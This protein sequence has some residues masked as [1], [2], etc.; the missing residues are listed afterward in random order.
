MT[1]QAGPGPWRQARPELVIAGVFVLAMAAAG[2]ALAGWPGLA[3]VATVAAV[4]ALL[5]LRGLAPR[6]AAAAARQARASDSAARSIT[7]YSQRRFLV[8]SGIANRAFYQADLQPLLEHLLAARLAERHGVNLYREP[9]AARRA[10]VR[11]AGDEALWRWIDPARTVPA[12]ARGI[13]RRTLARLIDR[14]EH[15]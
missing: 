2:L 10:F 12:G 4:I 9:E 3:V 8:A 5:V 7:G 1:E 14:L 6:P 11:T 15:L 13:P